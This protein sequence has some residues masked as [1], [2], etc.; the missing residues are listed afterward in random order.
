MA[1]IF[2]VITLIALALVAFAKYDN[3]KRR[4]RRFKI[5]MESESLEDERSKMFKL[6]NW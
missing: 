4:R 2:G 5:L 3:W 6:N 1:G